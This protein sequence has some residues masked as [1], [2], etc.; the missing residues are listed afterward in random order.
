MGLLPMIDP[1]V[2][3]GNLIQI[4]V[5][6][7]GGVSVFFALRSDVRVIR[8]DMNNLRER[9]D[10]LSEAFKQ[11][12]DILAKVAVQDER[13]IGWE[14]RIQSVERTIDE[15]RHGQGFISPIRT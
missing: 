7:M 9:Q 1:T 4:V 13:L 11:L 2:S 10:A 6:V 3:V 14:R 8:H 5:I 12:G 15:L